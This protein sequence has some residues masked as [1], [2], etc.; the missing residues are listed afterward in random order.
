M[1]LHIGTDEAGYG[2]NLGPL[3]VAATVWRVAGDDTEAAIARAV[4]A[5][6]GLASAHRAG[7]AAPL[8]ADS[9]QIHRGSDGF[10]A[11]ERG[12]A[13]GLAVATADVPG[14][15]ESL[16]RRLGPVSPRGGCR[17]QWRL[18]ADLRLP[19]ATDPAA[20][21]G[22]ATR[23]RDALAKH[24]VTLERVACRCVYPAEFNAAL[25][26]GL[27]KS[28]ILSAAT[29]DLAADLRAAA[30]DAPAVI[31]CD[32]H[33]GRKRYGGLVARHFRRTLVQP[34]EETAA[35]S[36]YA[37]PPEAGAAG[38]A[39]CLIEFR[40]GGE[41]RAPVALAS[42]AAKYVREL[43]MQAFNAFWTA[44]LPGLAPT[45]GYPVDAARWRR[46]AAAALAAENVRDDDFWRRA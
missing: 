37:V 22:L 12:V 34:V 13:I 9:K 14:T 42:M 36:A 16:E 1:T 19:R 3:V 39:G 11:L 27:N 30:P 10:A 25:D 28:D 26:A 45:A 20:A 46:D 2:P 15:W 40:V 17:D 21:V 41:T 38:Q 23:A 5:V 6:D 32:R 29:L 7:R 33:G 8:W 18:L 43:A 35:R 31:W 44:R 4:A 24:G